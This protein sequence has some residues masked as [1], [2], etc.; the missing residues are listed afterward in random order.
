LNRLTNMV[1]AVGTSGYSYD[2]ANE[3]L[4]EDGPWASDTVSYTYNNRLRSS[5]S[6]L[7]PNADPWS[8]T[9][10]YDPARRLTNTTSAAGSFG[11][12]YDATRQLQV[13]RLSLPN[14]AYITNSFDSVARELSTELLK[15]VGSHF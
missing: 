10:A 8:Q 11:Y 3:L 1:D 14:G 15:G 2:A 5:M 6:V 4:S 7:Q 9:Y 13:A 12:A